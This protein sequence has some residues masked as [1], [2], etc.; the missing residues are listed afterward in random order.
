MANRE[1]TPADANKFWDYLQLNYPEISGQLSNWSLMNG[2][3]VSFQPARMSNDDYI[4]Y[5][6]ILYSWQIDNGFWE[7][8]TLITTEQKK[9]TFLRNSLIGLAPVNEST[10]LITVQNV[11][12]GDTELLIPE[13]ITTLKNRLYI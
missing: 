10:T 13:N 6:R 12:G 1:I 2:A 9:V 5:Q 7:E 4:E 8:I 3:I 11:I